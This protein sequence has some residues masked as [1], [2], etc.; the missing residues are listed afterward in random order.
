[1]S[2][3]EN[4]GPNIPMGVAEELEDG[5]LPGPEFEMEMDDIDIEGMSLSPE[6]MDFMSAMQDEVVAEI[7]IPHF[8]NLAEYL[9]DDELS[10][11]A[12]K[13]IEGFDADKDSRAD[14]DET[15][16]RGLDLLGLKFE[17]TGT[18]FQ[19]SC[20][21]THP[22]IIE[23]AVKFQSKASQEILPSN[24]PVRTQIIGD[25]DSQ[26]VQQS[27]R[28]RKFMNYEL[29]EMMPEYFDEMERMLFHLPIVGSAIVKM[30]YDAGLAR[31]T[32]EH[33]PIDQ[34]YVNYSATDLRRADRYT[35]VIYK[36][37]VDLRRDIRAGMY[38]DI[39][40]LSDEPDGQG[41]SDNEISSKIDEIMGLA[42]NMSEDPEY[43]LLEQHCYMELEDD[44][45]PYPYII[46]VEESSRS[47]LSLRRNYREDDPLSEKMIHFTH[48]RYVPGF[49]FYGLGLIHLIGNLTMTATSA[50]RALVD[51]GQFANLPGGFKAKGVRVVGDNDPISPGEFKEVEAL[52]MDLNKAIVNLPY[53]EPSQT[54]FQLLGFVS[55]AAEKFADQ[56]DQVVSDAASYG[57]VGTTM[58]LLEASAKFFTAVHKR[59]HHAQRQQFKILAQINETFVPVNGYPYATPEGDMTIFAQDFDGRV[60]VLP[61]SDPNIPSRAH[62]LSLSSL[63][64]QLS[65]QTP[66]GTFNTPELIRQVLEAADFPNIDQVIPKKQEAQPGDPVT[67]IMNATKGMPIAAF[68][69]QD[70]EAHI[71]VKT[72]FLSDPTS[73]ASDALK[74]FVPI[75][76]A[77]IQEHMMLRYKTQIEGVVAQTVPPEQ[78][79]MAVQQGMQDAIIAEAA[80]RVAT[81]NQ[82]IVSGGTPEQQ[83][84]ALQGERVRLDEEKLQLDAIKDAANIATKNRQLDLKEDQ[85]RM[86]ALKDG[87]KIMSEKEEAELDREEDRRKM[88]LDLLADVAKSGTLE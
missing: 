86:V 76:Q 57:P 32:A 29:T 35:H 4:Y 85:Q 37:P 80:A 56:T 61:V 63:A 82:Q 84:V 88:L 67:D 52:G 10:D 1:M 26:I 78:Y 45:R 28:V 65:A 44:D 2:L 7:E 60:D 81:A 70:H 79:Q 38:A 66:P 23:S 47:V 24:G 31:P 16:T 43:T 51:A 64:L 5:D 8:A 46:T 58:A 13:V 83:L 17:E 75:I 18:A 15:L 59:L 12:E 39:E 40:D 49:G 50:M 73:G 41:R 21:A 11:V 77:N 25:P 87:I 36:S 62:R 71:Q 30:Y 19:G 20:A 22:L 53:K 68:P 33:I 14:W 72:N 27:N 34:F 55:G 42:G 54:L 74:Q 6:D 48:Y 9:G 3:I 69:G